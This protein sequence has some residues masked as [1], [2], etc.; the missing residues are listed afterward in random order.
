PAA[1]RTAHAAIDRAGKA[2]ARSAPQ[3]GGGTEGGGRR[4]EDGGRRADDGGRRAESGGWPHGGRRPARILG[5]RGR[6]G[7][8]D[9]R[10]GVPR[11]SS[12]CEGWSANR[13]RVGQLQTRRRRASPKLQAHGFRAGE[14]RL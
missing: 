6:G 9:R 8:G 5:N 4:T 10:W 14:I 1:R 3:V 7:A 11:A 13:A 2:T 12:L